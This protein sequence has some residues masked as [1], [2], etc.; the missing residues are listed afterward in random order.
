MKPS[1]E[2]EVQR[3]SGRQQLEVEPV[4]PRPSEIAAA[5]AEGMIP[6]SACASARTIR[7]SIQACRRAALVEDRRTSSVPQ[8]C[9]AS[10]V[11]QAGAH[12]GIAAR[13]SDRNGAG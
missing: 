12:A 8:R 9:G 11:R 4:G 13:A 2:C 7:I 5:A 3:V 6:S 10:A 1:V